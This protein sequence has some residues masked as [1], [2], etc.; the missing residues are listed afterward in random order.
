M[1]LLDVPRELDA[2]QLACT[3]FLNLE[4]ELLDDR[5]LHAW[6]NLLAPDIDYRVPTRVTRERA[7]TLSE[8]SA[9]SFH[10]I[11]DFASLAARVARFDT[12]F[13]WSEDP[14]SRTRRIVSNVRV[15]PGNAS[16]H[17][18]KS[19]FLLFRARGDAP[20]QI[21]AGE[22]RDSLREVGGQLKLARRF[23]LLDHTSL[24]M[25]NLAVFL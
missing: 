20:P 7:T 18:V 6:L 21:L 4:A 15:R 10:L 11:D 24:P 12:E 22:R 3:R 9:H 8:F 23:V 13:A 2:L 1:S 16:E 25:E 17:H 19:N 5:K 14:P